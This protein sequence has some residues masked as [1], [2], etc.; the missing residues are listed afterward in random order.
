MWTVSRLVKLSLNLSLLPS[1]QMPNTLNSS[2]LSPPHRVLFMLGSPICKCYRVIIQDIFR[3]YGLSA[4]MSSCHSICPFFPLPKHIILAAGSCPNLSSVL[5]PL[6]LDS[7]RRAGARK[8]WLK[9]S[10]QAQ[11]WSSI[12][13]CPLELD[14]WQVAAAS[15]GSSRCSGDALKARSPSGLCYCSTHSTHLLAQ[16]H[17]HIWRAYRPV[18]EV[19]PTISVIRLS[20]VF[21]VGTFYG[22]TEMSVS[23]IGDPPGNSEQC[24]SI[25][26]GRYGL[27]RGVYPLNLHPFFYP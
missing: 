10:A 26:S 9:L 24:G 2:L 6:P 11:C 22:D 21:V 16:P 19:S 1:S 3:P 7:D 25:I 15:V 23:I 17:S 12:L 8:F 13:R 14:T 20:P 4:V 5:K 27:L 18:V